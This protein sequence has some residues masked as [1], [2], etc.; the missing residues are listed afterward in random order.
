[1]FRYVSEVTGDPINCDGG[2]FP[3]FPIPDFPNK[4]QIPNPQKAGNALVTP[5]VFW[6]SMGSG[7]CLLSSDPS[8]RLPAYTIQRKL[9]K[10]NPPLTSLVSGDHHGVQSVKKK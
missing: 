3:T 5:L 7:D 1:M 4:P 6:V 9:L 10:A 2:P 8:T